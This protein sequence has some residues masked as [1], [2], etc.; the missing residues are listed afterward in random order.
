MKGLRKIL[1]VLWTA[2]ITN[3]WILNK[4][5][6]KKELSKTVKAKKLA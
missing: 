1:Q 5:G 6:V 4:A 2:E 3:E